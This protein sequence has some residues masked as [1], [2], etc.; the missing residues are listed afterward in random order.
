MYDT[1]AI[2]Q[3]MQNVRNMLIL[4]SRKNIHMDA[5]APQLGRQVADIHIH[6]ASVFA[7][8]YRERAGVIGK[9]GNI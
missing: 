9:H 8:Q 2:S 5:K 3:I 6:P 7:A 1:I 4:R